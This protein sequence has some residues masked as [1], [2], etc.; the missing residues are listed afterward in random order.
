[1]NHAIKTGV[2]TFAKYLGAPTKF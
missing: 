1:M 2:H